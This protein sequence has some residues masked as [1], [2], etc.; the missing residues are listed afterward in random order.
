[1]IFKRTP[2]KGHVINGKGFVNRNL[3]FNA[4]QFR[5]PSIGDRT[6]IREPGITPRSHAGGDH[7]Y[8]LFNRQH[9]ITSMLCT[10]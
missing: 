4:L 6:C 10:D 9:T 8:Y 3:R 5:L 1:M 2:S 7:N